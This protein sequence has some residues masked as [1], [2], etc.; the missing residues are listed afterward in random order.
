MSTLK[1]KNDSFCQFIDQLT[2]PT[3]AGLWV[4]K[5]AKQ[6][7]EMEENDTTSNEGTN[8]GK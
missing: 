7:K 8:N 4:E 3:K 6:L 2:K 5:A 1:L